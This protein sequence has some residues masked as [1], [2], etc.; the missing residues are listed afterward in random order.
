MDPVTLIVAAL[1]TGA[2]AAAQDAA[3][4][5]V[6]NGYN[7]L[8]SL[9]ARKFGSKPDV[10]NAVMQVEKKPDSENRQGVLKEELQAAGADQDDELLQ[11]VKSFLEL[12]EKSG[13]QTGVTYTATNTGSGAIAQGQGAVAA[14][15]GGIAVGGNVSG[16]IILGNNNQV[17]NRSG[18]IDINAQGGS[19][20]ITG[21]IVGRD[22]KTN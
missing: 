3:T 16:G 15:Q 21:D 12:L 22:K 10:I 5:V 2:A 14:G 18:G 13:L 8:K 11:Q 17:T 4:D 20:N 9:I 6:K 7:G 19:V 1:A